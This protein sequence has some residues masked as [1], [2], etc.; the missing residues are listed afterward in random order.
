MGCLY[1]LI[2]KALHHNLPLAY[3]FLT[4][5]LDRSVLKET[6]VFFFISSGSSQNFPVQSFPL[7]FF[8]SFPIKLC[9]ILSNPIEFCQIL[10]N[11][12]KSCQ[13]VSNPVKSSQILSNPVES[14]QILLNPVKSYQILWKDRIVQSFRTEKSFQSC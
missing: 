7:L 11:L 8:L 13:I 14:S 5:R 2:L 12:V 1:S 4:A 3:K 9:L 6:K 10:W